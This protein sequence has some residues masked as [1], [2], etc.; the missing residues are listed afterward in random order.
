MKEY[1]GALQWVDNSPM[2]DGMQDLFET[3]QEALEYVEWLKSIIK[4]VKFNKEI[5]F[6]IIR[7][8]VPK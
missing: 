3:K 2:I 7:I 6:T 8:K 5:T 4:E 1:Y